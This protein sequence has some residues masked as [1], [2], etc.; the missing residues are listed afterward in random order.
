M[1]VYVNTIDAN[2]DEIK[3][4]EYPDDQRGHAVALAGRYAQQ[5][6]DAVVSKTPGKEPPAPVTADSAHVAALVEQNRLLQA[7]LDAQRAP[8]NAPNRGNVAD[9]GTADAGPTA[10]P[11]PVAPRAGVTGQV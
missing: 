7:Q 10:P 5:G 1:T 11:A 9:A 2:G 6:I 4:N 3:A 8:L